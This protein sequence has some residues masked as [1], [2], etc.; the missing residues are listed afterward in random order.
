MNSD[1]PV[2]PQSKAT[3]DEMVVTNIE[4]TTQL[5]KRV[6]YSDGSTKE[7]YVT[8]AIAEVTP[9]ASGTSTG[10]PTVQRTTYVYSRISYSSKS[11]GS[12]GLLFTQTGSGHKVTYSS[13]GPTAQVLAMAGRMIDA[14]SMVRAEKTGSKNSPISGTWYSLGAPNS[15]LYLPK[16]ACTLNAESAAYLSNGEQVV[17][18][19][20]LST[21]TL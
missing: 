10:G 13:S 1:G 18:N 21:D 9:R 15:S 19:Y 7:D 20:F 3:I 5:L 11:D 8:T 17:M 4:Y 12:G 6:V 2:K 16:V 14:G